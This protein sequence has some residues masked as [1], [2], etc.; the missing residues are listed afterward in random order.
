MPES[1]SGYDV[2]M[3]EG[4]YWWFTGKIKY[5]Q[6]E[7]K[8]TEIHFECQREKR[9]TKFQWKYPFISRETRMVKFWLAEYRIFVE[10]V[11][12]EKPI[13]TIIDCNEHEGS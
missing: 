9:Y 4:I 3:Y 11:A 5:I 12:T 1:R 7:L 8:P 2:H 6:H 10:E 13:E